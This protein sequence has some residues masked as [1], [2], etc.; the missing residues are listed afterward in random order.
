MMTTIKKLN[1]KYKRTADEK[2]TTR[3]AAKKK[4]KNTGKATSFISSAKFDD[5]ANQI[6]HSACYAVD[7]A[8]L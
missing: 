2:F 5:T 8:F 1:N 3:A 4:V 6:K 7:A